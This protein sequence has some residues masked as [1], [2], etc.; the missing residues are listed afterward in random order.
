MRT[1]GYAESVPL[2]FDTADPRQIDKTTWRNP[3][4]GDMVDVTYFDLV[5]DLPAPLEDL[6]LCAGARPSEAPRTT[7]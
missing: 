3:R 6:R 7:A 1:A 5:P 2:S 4:T